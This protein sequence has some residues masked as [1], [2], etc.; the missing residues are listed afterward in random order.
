M[1]PPDVLL[2]NLRDRVAAFNSRLR[3]L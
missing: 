2:A 1:H 3:G